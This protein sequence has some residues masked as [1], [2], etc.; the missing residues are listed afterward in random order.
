M[1]FPLHSRLKGAVDKLMNWN[2]HRHEL[3]DLAALNGAEFSAIARDMNL[4][5]IE[6][7]MLTAKKRNRTTNLHR[8]LK[9]LDVDIE[10][11]TERAVMRDMAR[12]CAFC[13][14]TA[15]CDRDL[16]RDNSSHTYGQYCPNRAT[17]EALKS[18]T[19]SLQEIAS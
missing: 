19:I 8:L 1:A 10:N 11:T 9:A 12:V 17:I 2:R 3:R 14:V 16:R 15:R 6:L 5:S 18:H 7:E 13:S 4:S